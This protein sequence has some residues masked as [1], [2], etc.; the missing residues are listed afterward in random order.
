M[1]RMR[2]SVFDRYEESEVATLLL[3]L[4]VTVFVAANLPRIRAFP[5]W[6]LP[7]CAVFC[8]LVGWTA[9]VLEDD[10]LVPGLNLVEHLAG[11]AHTVL[12]AYWAHVLFRRSPAR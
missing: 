12:M 3:G 11:V 1:P 5:R 2:Y 6:Q 8:L 9:S 7:L 4:V 10:G